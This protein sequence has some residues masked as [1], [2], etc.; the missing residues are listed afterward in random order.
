MMKNV[1]LIIFL[2]LP[3]FNQLIT[4]FISIYVIK[5][6]KISLTFLVPIWIIKLVEMNDYVDFDELP[7]FLDGTCDLPYKT[8]PKDVPSAH[9]LAE[10]L[11]IGKSAADKLIKH[12][13]WYIMCG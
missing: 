11:S 12:L 13:E 5:Y 4:L 7:D 6:L 9:D 10:Q 1:I 2:K 8:V 3:L